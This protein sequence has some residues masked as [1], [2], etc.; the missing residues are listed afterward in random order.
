MTPG[1]SDGGGCNGILIFTD[2]VP[3]KARKTYS[4]ADKGMNLSLIHI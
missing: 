1:E 3:P 4:M 2:T